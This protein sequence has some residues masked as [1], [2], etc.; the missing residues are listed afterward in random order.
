MEPI[1]SSAYP[2]KAMR[3]AYSVLDLSRFT[4]KTG[5]TPRHWREAL[6]DYVRND[7]KMGKSATS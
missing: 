6:R 4:K 5:I 1:P 7:L 2:T 3:P